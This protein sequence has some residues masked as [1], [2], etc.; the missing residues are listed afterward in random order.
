MDYPYA[1]II[2]LKYALNRKKTTHLRA[3]ACVYQKKVVP[4]SVV[5]CICSSTKCKK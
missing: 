4:L 5:L 3:S 2:L 1:L